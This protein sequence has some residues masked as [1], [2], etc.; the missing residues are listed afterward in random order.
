MSNSESSAVAMT[1][2]TAPF[3]PTAIP[4]RLT[5]EDAAA[6]A[7]RSAEQEKNQYYEYKAVYAPQ[8][9]APFLWAEA[10]GVLISRKQY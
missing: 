7:A 10:F 6:D 9:L 1:A 2:V 4:A 8:A 5:P 3:L